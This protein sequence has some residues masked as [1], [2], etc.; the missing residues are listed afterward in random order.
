MQILKFSNK[1]S[2][3]KNFKA[4]SELLNTELQDTQ[5]EAEA[6]QYQMTFDSIMQDLANYKMTCQN[7]MSSST[8]PEIKKKFQEMGKV[9]SETTV[10]LG[11]I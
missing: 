6:D 7:L 4:D 10:A 11:E 8:S 2:S 9:L 5:Y 1:Q 3:T